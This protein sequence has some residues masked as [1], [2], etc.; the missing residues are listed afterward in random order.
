[1]KPAALLRVASALTFIHAVLHTIGGAF[2]QGAPGAQQ[3]A[4][5]A[6]KANRFP[7]MGVMRTYW[8]FQ[9]GLGLAVSIFLFV[10]AVV[11]WQLGSLVKSGVAALRPILGAFVLAY[12]ALAVNSYLYFFAGPVVVEL[13]I[14]ACLAAAMFMRPRPVQ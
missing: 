5:L 9:Q 1:M 10:E 4:L 12:V 14:A 8:D 13:L 3:T 2:G 7:A 11:F 6:M